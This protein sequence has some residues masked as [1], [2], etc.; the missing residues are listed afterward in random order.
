MP[1]SPLNEF[2]TRDT[3]DLIRDGFSGIRANDIAERLEIWIRGRIARTVSYLE[4]VAD[5]EILN[6]TF[7]EVFHFH[8]ATLDDESNKMIAE[9]RRR[10]AFVDRLERTNP[11]LF[12]KLMNQKLK[13]H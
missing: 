8:N 9:L 11:K 5:P 1:T 4:F 3:R 10:K 12:E 6:R 7:I 13:K 2:D